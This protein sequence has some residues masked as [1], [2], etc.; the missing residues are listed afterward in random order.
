MLFYRFSLQKAES[1][2]QKKPIVE[3]WKSLNPNIY[4][5]KKV[6]DTTGSL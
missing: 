4:T 2:K 6:K 1:E 5:L 3:F